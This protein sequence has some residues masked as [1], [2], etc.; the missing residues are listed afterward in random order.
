MI[1]PD[2]ALAASVDRT[3]LSADQRVVQVLSR[4]TF[5]ARPG[6]VERVRKM[7]VEAFIAQ[8]LDPDSID[9]SALMKRLEKLPT[10]NLS[11]PVLAE[12]YNPPKPVQLAVGGGQLAGA[13]TPTPAQVAVG[14][15][16]SAVWCTVAGLAWSPANS[17]LNWP[18]A[19]PCR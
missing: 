8:Q 11:T 16:Q 9:D 14:S 12:Q 17:R 5:G 1:A 15:G 2:A 19:W 3:A 18:R 13:G 4:L 6:D 7:G 10:L